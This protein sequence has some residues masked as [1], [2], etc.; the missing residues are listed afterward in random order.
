MNRRNFIRDTAIT[1]VSLTA[2][3]TVVKAADGTFGGDCDTT[4]DILGPFYRPD[5]PLRSDLTYEGLAG[6][7][8]TVK[9]KVFQPDCT[10]ALANALVEIWHCDTEGNYDND[11]SAY[12]QRARW[13]TNA[14]GEFSFKTI[15][16]GKYLNGELYRPSHIHFR[17]S[18]AGHKELVSQI[19]FQGDP[20]ITKDPWA[21]QQKAKERILEIRPEDTHGNLAIQFDIY[22]RKK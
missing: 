3:G 8:I 5:A 12:R 14:Q 15:L 20:H 9:G 22:M 21:S 11:T 19:Y 2:F 7:R 18:E 16:P 6:N 1:A 17:V 10:T 4:N 13:L